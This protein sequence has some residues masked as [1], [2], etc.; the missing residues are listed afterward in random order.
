MSNEPSTSLTEGMAALL[1]AS[2][3]RPP[4]DDALS[5]LGGWERLA[6]DG[7][8]LADSPV[9]AQFVGLVVREAAHPGN[10]A[11]TY[12]DALRAITAAVTAT[13]NP[14]IFADSLETLLSSPAALEVVGTTLAKSLEGIVEA[15]QR[16][17]DQN[18]RAAR[19]AADA[20]EALTRLN[21]TGIGSSFGFLALLER[22]NTPMPKPLGTAVIRAVGTA[23]D[24]W[25][26]AASLAKVVRLV[27]GL[28][29]P[30]GEVRSDADPED[31]ASDA[32]W[33]LAGIELVGA[34]RASDLST[35]AKNLEASAAYLEIARDAYEREDADVLLTVVEVLRGL[36]QES[37]VPPSVDALAMPLLEPEAL[38]RLAERVRRIN[39]A[40]IGLNHWYG[41]PKRAALLAWN[42]LANDLNRLRVEFA[43]NSFYKA[44][45][46]VDGLL[47]IYMG[48][49]SVAVVRREEDADG[50][51]TLI[52]PIIESG[53]ARTAGLLSNLEDHTNALERQ[54][55][56]SADDRRSALSEQL[57]AARTVLAAAKTHALGGA[58]QGKD[59][60]G[61]G[62][63]PLPPPLNQLLPAGSAAATALGAMSKQVL[64]E[65]G[66]ALDDITIGK[67][68]LNLIESS[69][70]STIRAALASS[71]DYSG[72][73][74]AAVDEVLRLIIR[75]VTTRTN[76]QSDLYAYVFDPK[77]NEDSIHLDLYNYLAS[78]DL[79]SI[80]EFEV[81]HVGG[82]RIDLRLKFDGFA[83][84]IE[85]KVDSTKVP[86]D[87]KTAY[88]K[89]AVAYQGTDIRIGFLVA[90]R[91]KAFDPSGP[92]PH[93]SALIG[94]TEFGIEGDSIPRHIVTVQVPGSRTK[95]SDM[96]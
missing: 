5:A 14:A 87:D 62:S 74:A 18:A 84:H 92:P 94:H 81:Q 27:A 82:G 95:P 43:R 45:I 20:L 70:Y 64:I 91:H 90:L 32:A 78:S 79:G 6:T 89:Q 38:G 44:E 66:Q 41:D 28:D 11:G 26:H 77:A 9:L 58:G 57:E 88:L 60:G 47:Q 80:V 53:F 19:R 67:R 49:R 21:L 7:A 52:Q 15:F 65:L 54:V 8:A 51:L 72:A 35:M 23:V 24:H 17:E 69:V 71:P 93:L 56:E 30:A 37:G 59:D 55:A 1:T 31:V 10:R 68:S 46:V 25:P 3:G 86:M 16:L 36:L 40:S 96:R 76:A 12:A 85:M 33:A 75:F 50:L 61:M 63:T 22:F 83:I 29:P 73:A 4:N 13:E 2:P 42:Q 39:I 48:S 34:L